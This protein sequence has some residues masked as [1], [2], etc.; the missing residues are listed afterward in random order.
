[1]PKL[2]LLDA[3]PTTTTTDRRRKPASRMTSV[4]RLES[5]ARAGVDGR[6]WYATAT[7]NVVSAARILNCSPEWF[8]AV[9]GVTSP[10]V[11][12]SRNVKLSI[13]YAL[14]GSTTGTM[15]M[16]RV[17]LAKL[18]AIGGRHCQELD[19]MTATMGPKTG[20][21]A[22]AL[23]GDLDAVVLDVWMARAL[24]LDQSQFSHKP[25]HRK[26]CDRIRQVADLLGWRP[27]EVQAAIWTT[28][29]RAH[30]TDATVP[31]FTISLDA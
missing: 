25:T 12:V 3:T 28:A 7:S 4:D 27:A 24:G 14:N 9:L 1:M 16:V 2:R 21:F 23:A 13:A 6:H 26:A 19:G 20:P 17:G 15:P 8:A 22:R 31:Q 10:R 11:H 5:M 29:Y 30:Y 18:S